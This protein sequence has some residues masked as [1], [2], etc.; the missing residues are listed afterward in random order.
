MSVI[1]ILVHQM[2]IVQTSLDLSNVNV[3]MDS[4]ETASLVMV[5]VRS[6]SVSSLIQIPGTKS[7]REGDTSKW[8]FEGW[9]IFKVE[10]PFVWIEKQIVD[11]LFLFSQGIPSV[12]ILIWLF[13]SHQDINEC[14]NDPCSPNANCTNNVGS[15]TCQCKNGF[16]GDGFTCNGM[17]FSCTFF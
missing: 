6:I 1:P 2:P 5:C 13:F 11:C 15:F 3:K 10:L 17:F 14:D 9:K 12:F 7:L 4:Q 16:S 8:H